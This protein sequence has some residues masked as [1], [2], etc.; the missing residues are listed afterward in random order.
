MITLYT[1]A[2][3]NG[4]KVSIALEEIGL[5]YSVHHMNLPAGEQREPWYLDINPNGRVPAI[6]DHDAAELSIFESGAILLYLSEKTG[7]LMPGDAAGRSRVT[8]WLMFQMSGLGPMMGQANVFYRYMPEKVPV[9][10]NRFQAETKRLLQVLDRQLGKSD[11]LAGEYSIADIA[12]W[13]WARLHAWAGVEIDNLCNL[14]RWLEAIGDRPGV[15]RGVVVPEDIL[16]KL[17]DAA[18]AESVRSGARTM[19][20]TGSPE[21]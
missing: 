9:A 5:G 1:A 12:N 2:S 11:Y 8:Q 21:S 20:V 3:P 17:R 14:R 7:R 18:G 6:V 4:Q 10:I 19:V 13:C 15:K 16:A